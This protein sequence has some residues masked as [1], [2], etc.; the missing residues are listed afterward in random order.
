MILYL[1]R[2]QT[3]GWIVGVGRWDCIEPWLAIHLGEGKPQ[4]PNLHYYNVEQKSRLSRLCRRNHKLV[5]DSMERKAMTPKHCGLELGVIIFTD[6]QL[7]HSVSSQAV[8]TFCPATGSR[9]PRTREWG[10]R[11]CHA[12]A[13][14]QPFWAKASCWEPMWLPKRKRH[15][16]HD[17]AAR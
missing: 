7:L 14:Q 11:M 8:L 4:I 6:C 12:Y 15:N 17:F 13:A 16:W 5:I 9:W 2:D 10:R 3:M 1:T